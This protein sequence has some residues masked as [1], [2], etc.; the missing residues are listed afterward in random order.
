VIQPALPVVDAPVRKKREGKPLC[1][2]R[3][4]MANCKAAGIPLIPPTAA[5]IDY[6]F[7]M[8]L[9]KHKDKSQ[10]FLQLAWYKFKDKFLNDD[11][12]RKQR[13]WVQHF[14]NYVKNNYFR[15]WRLD[16]DSYVLTNLGLEVQRQMR[17]MKEK[18]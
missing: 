15:L 17:R 5:V 2:F 3:T 10:D 11:P 18:P 7:Q 13:D 4:Y 16:N 14:N 12:E 6:A 1:T 8:G 9:P